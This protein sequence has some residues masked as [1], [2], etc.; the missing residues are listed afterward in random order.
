MGNKAPTALA[1]LDRHRVDLTG[2]TCLVTGCT[3]GMGVEIARALAHGGATVY[4]T[5]RNSAELTR[6]AALLNNEVAVPRVQ[7]LVMDQSSLQSVRAAAASFLRQSTALHLLVCNAGLM[8]VPYA[9]SAEGADMQWAVNHIAHQLLFTLLQPALLAAAPSRVVSVSST[10]WYEFGSTSVDHSRLPSV[11]QSQYS[12][13]GAYQQSKLANV[14]FA[15]HVHTEWSGSGITAY[16][17]NPGVV[18]SGLQRGFLVL[19]I[20]LAGPLLKSAAQGAAS[21]V[22]CGV[23]PG[24]ESS[25]GQYF[26]DCAVTSE[27]SKR[28]VSHK[29]AARLWQWTA[30]FIEQHKGTGAQQ[31]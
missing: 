3:S 15:L 31:E 4:V 18:K 5:G 27:I 11:P 17:L 14:L 22:Y 30:D 16:S 10:A 9:L 13:L 20:A 23:A 21:A 6:V 26:T 25:S 24:L 7:T 19:L 29:D 1:I 8:N 12:A 28:K 2:R